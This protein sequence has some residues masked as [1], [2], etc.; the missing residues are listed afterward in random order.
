MRNQ[1]LEEQTGE[2]RS[3]IAT[4]EADLKTRAPTGSGFRH[5]GLGAALGITLGIGVSYA[6]SA[7]R[8]PTLPVETVRTRPVTVDELGP[9]IV[10][11]P[12]WTD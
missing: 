4:L 2:L 8:S 9:E 11:A 6:F 7:L 12:R 1:R 5:L 3:K 10:V